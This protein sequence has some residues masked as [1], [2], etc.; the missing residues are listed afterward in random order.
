MHERLFD[1]PMGLFVQD[2][3]IYMTTRYQIWR[4]DNFL[5]DGEI[6]QNSDRLYVPA[7]SYTTG[8]INVH[9][10]VISWVKKQPIIE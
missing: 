2:N 1:K 8:A 3:S 5:T 4:L 6:Y 7:Q 9:D 10:V